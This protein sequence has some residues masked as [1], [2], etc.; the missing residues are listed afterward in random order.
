[1]SLSATYLLIACV[2]SSTSSSSIARSCSTWDPSIPSMESSASFGTSWLCEASL[3]SAFSALTNEVLSWHLW[4][5]AC[6]F[7]LPDTPIQRLRHSV[8][9]TFA[10]RSKNSASKQQPHI[11]GYYTCYIHDMTCKYMYI[12][13]WYTLFILYIYIY[14]Y[15]VY[16]YIYIFIYSPKYNIYTYIYIDIWTYGIHYSHIYIYIYVCI[17]IY[18]LYGSIA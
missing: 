18:P 2:S 14:I 4:G 15:T 3:K 7:G 8:W 17:C 10:S 11:I 5:H 13:I 6:S 9:I 1:M 16:T 12:Y